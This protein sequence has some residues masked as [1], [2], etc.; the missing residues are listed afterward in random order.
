MIP[1]HLLPALYQESFV[2]LLR[3]ELIGMEATLASSESELLLAEAKQESLVT[4]GARLVQEMLESETARKSQGQ[5]L[6][7]KQKTRQKLERITAILFDYQGLFAGTLFCH[8]HRGARFF[9]LDLS[10]FA[11]GHGYGEMMI[12]DFVRRSMDGLSI[13]I[14]GKKFWYLRGTNGAL[15]FHPHALSDNDFSSDSSAL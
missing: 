15:Y 5:N 12:E 3:E 7:E 2:H 4:R 8:D 9:T 13:V 6:L 10:T 14:A 1:A 11:Y